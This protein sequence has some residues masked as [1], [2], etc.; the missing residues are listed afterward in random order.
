MTDKE[1][2]VWMKKSTRGYTSKAFPM[3]IT[4]MNNSMGIPTAINRPKRC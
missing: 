4:V 3:N 2:S 1:V